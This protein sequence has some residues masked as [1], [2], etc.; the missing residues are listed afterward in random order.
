M[1]RVSAR[2]RLAVRGRKSVHV[3]YGSPAES[4]RPRN[5]APVSKSLDDPGSAICTALFE[6]L[7]AE[8]STDA[9]APEAARGVAAGFTARYG[10]AP[11]KPSGVEHEEL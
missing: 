6:T 11:S 2:D 5:T 9:F 1:T 8:G 7:L 3:A 4:G 10:R